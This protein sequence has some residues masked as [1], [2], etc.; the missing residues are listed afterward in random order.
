MNL[1]S[2][3]E[4]IQ[5]EQALSLLGAYFSLNSEYQS[6]CVVSPL[7]EEHIKCFKKIRKAAMKCIEKIPL[8]R[9]DLISLQLIQALRYEDIHEH[10]NQVDSPL[11]DYLLEKAETDE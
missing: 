6:Q 7:K 11:R 8:E 10:Y 3:W 4:E 9:L 5:L 1:L 2:E